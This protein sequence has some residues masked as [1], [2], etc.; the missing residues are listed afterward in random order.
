MD[1]AYWALNLGLPET[2]E[3]TSSKLFK[4]S[5]PAWSIIRYLFPAIPGRPAVKLTWYDGP[6]RPPAEL[7]E[8]QKVSGNGSIIVDDQGRLYIPH[9]WGDG[10]LLPKAS[11]AI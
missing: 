3:A 9:Y 5:A 8:G 2:I 7:F 1:V 10:M 4:E 6:K 11:S